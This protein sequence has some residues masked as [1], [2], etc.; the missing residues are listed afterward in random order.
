[1]S[2]KELIKYF[3]KFIV[4]NPSVRVTGVEVLDVQR[5]LSIRDGRHI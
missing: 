5:L 2:D 4:N 3:K 1:V